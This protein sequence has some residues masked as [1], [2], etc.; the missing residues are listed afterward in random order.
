MIGNFAPSSY[1]GM[2]GCLP[3]LWVF[4]AV[5]QFWCV[6]PWIV[7]LYNKSKAVT[8]SLLSVLAA[9]SLI[10]TMY[11]AWIHH[12]KVG[13]LAPEN[14]KDNVFDVVYK[15]PFTKLHLL[16]MSFTFS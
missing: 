2:S 13:L 14:L 6:M 4:S 3:W 8:F 16:L 9:G 1:Y 15:S 10:L 7:L 11:Y 12:F 5:F